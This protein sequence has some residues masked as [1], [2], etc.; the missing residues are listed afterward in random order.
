MSMDFLE[1]VEDCKVT[2]YFYVLIKLI[3]KVKGGRGSN[4]MKR[5][6]IDKYLQEK[7]QKI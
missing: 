2:R 6:N 7:K 1:D 5:L 4:G 3:Y